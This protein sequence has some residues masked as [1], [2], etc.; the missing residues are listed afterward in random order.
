MILFE[1]MEKGR[2]SRVTIAII[3]LSTVLDFYRETSPPAQLLLLPPHEGSQE[4][5]GN[6]QF[7]VAI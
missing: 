3:Q 1:K 4:K 2:G 6:I 7:P 5:S